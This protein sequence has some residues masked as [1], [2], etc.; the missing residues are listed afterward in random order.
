MKDVKTTMVAF[1]LL[2][3]ATAVTTQWSKFSRTPPSPFENL[4][5]T[6]NFQLVFQ[7]VDT[8]PAEVYVK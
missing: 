1:A 6:W 4:A 2:S 7:L 3:K 5:R 8:T